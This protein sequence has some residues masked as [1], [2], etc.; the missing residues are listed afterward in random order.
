MTNKQQSLETQSLGQQVGAS[1]VLTL[2]VAEGSQKL[3]YLQS[4]IVKAYTAIAKNPTDRNAG[5]EQSFVLP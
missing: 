3:Q 4:L 5:E 1:K 2:L